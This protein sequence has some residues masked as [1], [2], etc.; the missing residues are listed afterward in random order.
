MQV[1][2]ALQS[3]LLI[4]HSS[5]SAQTPA[6][7][8][9]NPDAQALHIAPLA[10]HDDWLCEARATQVVPMQQP[11]QFAAVQVDDGVKQTPPSQRCAAGQLWVV[12]R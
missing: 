1:A 2:L 10:P 7:E 8:Q 9:E 12:G 5:T 11:V 6:A 3:P 4:A